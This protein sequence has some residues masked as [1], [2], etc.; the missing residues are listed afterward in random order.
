MSCLLN[1]K[2]VINVNNFLKKIN[3]NIKLIELDKT[4][5]TAQEAA[6]SLN[7]KNGKLK[8]WKGESHPPRKTTAPTIDTINILAYSLKKKIDHLNPENSVI[9]PATSSDS[10]SGISNGVLFVSATTEIK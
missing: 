6:D 3:K 5:R 8:I 1:R 10:A 9:H 7:Q 2:N 4:A